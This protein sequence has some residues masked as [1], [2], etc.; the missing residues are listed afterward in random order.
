MNGTLGFRGSGGQKKSESRHVVAFMK[1]F[2]V[3]Y[4]ALDPRADDYKGQVLHARRRAE[5]AVLAFLKSRNINTKGARSVLRAL[6]PLHKSGVVDER[7]VAYKKL[8]AVG[9]I[10]DPAPPDTQEIFAIVGHV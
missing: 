6:R 1:I 4:F 8:I 2:L 10:V 3:G 5:G 7:I 9:S